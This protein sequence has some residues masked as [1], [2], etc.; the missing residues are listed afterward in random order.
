MAFLHCVCGI[1]EGK[2]VSI[3]WGAEVREGSTYMVDDE[4]KKSVSGVVMLL[5][6]TMRSVMSGDVC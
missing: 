4:K 6:R 3:A 1:L 2:R 5:S